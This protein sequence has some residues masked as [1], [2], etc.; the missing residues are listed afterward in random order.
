MAL[1]CLG[2]AEVEGQAQRVPV[3]VLPERAA[4][5]GDIKFTAVSDCH[6]YGIAVVS[7]VGQYEV[8]GCG[9]HDWAAPVAV[10]IGTG[11]GL[12]LN[13]VGCS[14]AQASKGVAVGV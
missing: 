9:E 13:F 14:S 6:T 11:V 4:S 8:I 12:H 7:S 10:A 1:F 5:E 2:V 3:A